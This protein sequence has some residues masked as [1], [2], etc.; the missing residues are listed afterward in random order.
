MTEN[1]AVSLS[2]SMDDFTAYTVQS[3][4]HCVPVPVIHSYK[5]EETNIGHHKFNFLKTT[6]L[7]P[8][9]PPP[10]EARQIHSNAFVIENYAFQHCCS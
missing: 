1:M 9:P 3:Q 2:P 6:H 4:I 8:L 7:L 5:W 10:G